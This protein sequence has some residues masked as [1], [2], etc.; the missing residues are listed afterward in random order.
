MDSKKT[1]ISRAIKK[2]SFKNKRANYSFILVDSWS[3]IC[4]Y[5]KNDLSIT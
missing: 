4:E 2:H 1:I 3:Q 5:L